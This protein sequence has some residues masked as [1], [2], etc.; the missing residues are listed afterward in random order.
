MEENEIFEADIEEVNEEVTEEVNEDIS[1]DFS[2]I[3]SEASSVPEPAQPVQDQEEVI[4]RDSA[5][6]L[7]S[8][9]NEVLRNEQIESASDSSS[10]GS[11]DGSSEDSSEVSSEGCSVFFSEY[12]SILELIANNTDSSSRYSS[13]LLSLQYAELD[14]NRFT[15]ELNDISLT[16]FLLILILVFTLAGLV[17]HFIRGIF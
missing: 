16:N 9:L 5:N 17:I 10:D 2:D 15:S 12:D 1:F 14:N 8:V 4:N 11:S 7:I 3:A 6:D 13:E